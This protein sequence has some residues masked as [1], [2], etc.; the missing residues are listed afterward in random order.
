MGGGGVA[1]RHKGH[2]IDVGVSIVWQLKLPISSIGWKS[3]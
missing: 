1:K 2:V 3:Y